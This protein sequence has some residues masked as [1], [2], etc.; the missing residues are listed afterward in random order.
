LRVARL[1]RL[2]S[3]LDFPALVSEDDGA[4][5]GVLTYVPKAQRWEVLTLH[6]ARRWTGV[7]TALIRS[8]E[9][10]AGEQDCGCLFLITT[11]DNV[12]ALRFYQRRGF[13]LRSLHP[14]A[15][16]KSRR[17]LKPEIPKLGDYGIPLRDEIELEKSIVSGD[18]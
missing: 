4:V 10:L 3:A 11:N 15:V 14:G 7:G 13:R 18:S 1:G 8:L 2:L 16:E 5:T 9:V 17:K 12:D 6:V